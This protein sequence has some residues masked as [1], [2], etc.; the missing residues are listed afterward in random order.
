MEVSLLPD[1]GV[2]SGRAAANYEFSMAGAATPIMPS[3]VSVSVQARVR[4]AFTPRP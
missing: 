2:A 4:F 1:Y 3:D